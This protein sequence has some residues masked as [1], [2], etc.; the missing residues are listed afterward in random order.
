MLWTPWD[1]R[2]GDVCPTR[3]RL[4]ALLSRLVMAK[5][6][7]WD[8]RRGGRGRLDTLPMFQSVQCVPVRCRCGMV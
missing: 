3:K 6:R 7:R 2:G 5:T 4:E 1:T 8:R